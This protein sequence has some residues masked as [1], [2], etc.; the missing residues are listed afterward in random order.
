MRRAGAVDLH[1]PIRL[2]DDATSI[3]TTIVHAKCNR[4]GK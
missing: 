3:G 1:H 4:T 2:V